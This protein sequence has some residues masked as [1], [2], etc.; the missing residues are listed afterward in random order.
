MGCGEEDPPAGPPLSEQLDQLEGAPPKLGALHKQANEL[1]EGNEG[2]FKAKLEELRGY[3]I[4]VNKWASWCAPCRQEFPLF[5][6]VAAKTG[7]EVV[8]LGVDSNDNDGEA[9]DFLEKFP[10]SYPTFKDPTLKVAAVFKATVAW[11]STAF[12]D[13]RGELAYLHQGPYREDQDLIDDI[14]RYAK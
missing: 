7:K 9:A 12:Y 14:E 10:V 1:L 4:V 2:A 13:E 6:R 3:P 8:F 11:P 5:A